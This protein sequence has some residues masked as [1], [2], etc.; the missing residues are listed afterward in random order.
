MHWLCS[1]FKNE[2]E[3]SLER[4]SSSSSS[5]DVSELEQGLAHSRE[6]EH[7]NDQVDSMSIF[8][9]TLNGHT[10][11]P[12][13]GVSSESKAPGT[14]SDSFNCK[15]DEEV[16]SLSFFHLDPKD[17]DTM[18]DRISQAGQRVLNSGSSVLIFS[19]IPG[20]REGITNVVRPVAQK[21]RTDLSWLS[22]QNQKPLR[23]D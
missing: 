23:S 3:T 13:Q 6:D 14:T 10:S 9:K 11:P 21:Q 8:L 4:F 20:S 2:R 16:N 1:L 17:P 15:P 12:L 7:S 19:T 22:K 18:S 5:D